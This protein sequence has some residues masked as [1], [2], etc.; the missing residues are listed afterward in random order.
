MN[1]LKKYPSSKCAWKEGFSHSPSSMMPR[2]KQSA[3]F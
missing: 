3:S 1:W 2:L